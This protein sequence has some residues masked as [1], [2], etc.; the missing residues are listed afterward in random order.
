MKIRKSENLSVCSP[1]INT[2]PNLHS[3]L[4]QGGTVEGVFLAQG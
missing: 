1:N 2:N 4:S 3:A